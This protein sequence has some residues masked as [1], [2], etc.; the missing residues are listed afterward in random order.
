M[1]DEKELRV[2]VAFGPDDAALIRELADREHRPVRFQVEA[3]ALEALRGRK[4]DQTI[5]KEEPVNAR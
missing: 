5:S 1:S 2:Q 4:A 3:L